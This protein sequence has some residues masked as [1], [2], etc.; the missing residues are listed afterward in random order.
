MS[1]VDY[2]QPSPSQRH[3]G[4]QQ[5]R[6]RYMLI[7]NESSL[8]AQTNRPDCI[9]IGK[10]LAEIFVFEPMSCQEFELPRLL[11]EHAVAF[12]SKKIN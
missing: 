7:S 5:R 6:Y 4:E 9:E 3:A 11:K 2:V 8:Q 12:L 10:F 1:S